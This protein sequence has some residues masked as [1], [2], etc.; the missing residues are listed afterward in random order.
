MGVSR[1]FVPGMRC[2]VPSSS[3]TSVPQCWV[4]PHVQGSITVSD[5]SVQ[6]WHSAAAAHQEGRELARKTAKGK[7]QKAPG[8]EESRALMQPFISSIN[9]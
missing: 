9:T 7:L 3:A 8:E 4:C 1:G 2:D 5:G 6:G